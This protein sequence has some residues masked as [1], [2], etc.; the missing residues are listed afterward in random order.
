MERQGELKD[1]MK[2]MNMMYE[3]QL[4]ELLSEKYS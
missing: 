2:N 1:E 4:M 3:E